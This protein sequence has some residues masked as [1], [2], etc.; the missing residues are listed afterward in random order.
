M[1]EKDA[2]SGERAETKERPKREPENP[3]ERQRSFMRQR[4]AIL[5]PHDDVSAETNAQHLAEQDEAKA[6]QDDDPPFAH[7]ERRKLL[8]QYRRRQRKK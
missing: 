1:D 7:E 6:E 3:G 5:S 2:P 4:A 8:A